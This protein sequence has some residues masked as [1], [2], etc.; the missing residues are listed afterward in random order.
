MELTVKVQHQVLMLLKTEG[1]KVKWKIKDKPSQIKF[2]DSSSIK[3]RV[4]KQLAPQSTPLDMY[5]KMVHVS[6]GYNVAI[7]TNMYTTDFY[8][9][10]LDSK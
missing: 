8:R 3:A 7:E 2:S 9:K 4:R 5:R 10:N 1:E 6:F